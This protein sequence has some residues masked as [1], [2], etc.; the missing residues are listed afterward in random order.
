MAAGSVDR[1]QWERAVDA[2]KIRPASTHHVLSALAHGA[3]RSL[4]VTTI[5][6]DLA[7]VTGL[8][9][10]TV[11]GALRQ[12]RAEGWIEVVRLGRRRRHDGR[13]LPSRYRL[14]LPGL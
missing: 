10:R 6:A 4:I 9:L 3:N 14:T 12:A 2:A 7:D 5:A 11:E 8:S 13:A 1:F